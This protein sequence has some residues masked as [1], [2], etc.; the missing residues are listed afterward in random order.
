MLIR[1]P[2]L[3]QVSWSSPKFLTCECWYGLGLPNQRGAVCTRQGLSNMLS[4]PPDLASG[5]FFSTIRLGTLPPLQV[6]ASR[7]FIAIANLPMTLSPRLPLFGTNVWNL[8]RPRIFCIK[9]PSF[10]RSASLNSKPPL[11]LIST[12]YEARSLSICF[13]KLALTWLFG[14]STA[15]QPSSGTLGL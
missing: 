9:S 14:A 5:G 6:F 8:S 15:L 2:G 7:D 1:V 13:T 4:C 10:D 3:G 11:P 12:R